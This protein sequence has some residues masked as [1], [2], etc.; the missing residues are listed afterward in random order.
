M[1]SRRDRLARKSRHGVTCVASSIKS[2]LRVEIFPSDGVSVTSYLIPVTD[3][4]AMV[5][6]SNA[7]RTGLANMPRALLG[8]R[9]IVLTRQIRR[10]SRYRSPDLCQGRLQCGFL[11]VVERSF[12]YRAAFA[13]EPVEDLL[14][15]PPQHPAH[16]AIHR[17]VAGQVQGLLEMTEFVWLADRRQRTPTVTLRQLG[18]R[19][20]SLS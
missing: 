9:S 16:G 20:W 3:G 17:V 12:Q 4:N 1:P 14:P 2:M 19:S 13:F 8:V 7:G 10:C 6:V 18:T 5:T 11:R 15:R